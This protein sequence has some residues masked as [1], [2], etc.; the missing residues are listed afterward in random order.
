MS[1]RS[2]FR[3]LVLCST[4]FLLTACATT[5]PQSSAQPECEGAFAPHYADSVFAI[6]QDCQ[7]SGELV[8]ASGELVAG[9]NTADLIFHNRQDADVPGLSLEFAWAKNGTRQELNP[10]VQEVMSGLYLIRNLQLP[11]LQGQL[12]VKA[13]KSGVADTLVF[14]L[15]AGMQQGQMDQMAHDHGDHGH[16][17]QDMTPPETFPTTV[18]SEDGAFTVSYSPVPGR[19]LMNQ[20][21][22]WEITVRDQNGDPVRAVVTADGDMPQHG[23]GLPTRPEVST[24]E[25]TG[26]Y[27][28]EGLK[29]HMP[30]WWRVILTIRTMETHDRAIFDFMLP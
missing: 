20:I 30:G 6:G 9:A 10:D 12:I 24:T 1:A 13:N 26:V 2:L 18:Q 21:H 8:P 5:G 3:L 29:F 7:L 25:Q 14:D 19:V 11:E 28:V 23:H 15:A 4:L 27:L 16:G 17:M 22:S